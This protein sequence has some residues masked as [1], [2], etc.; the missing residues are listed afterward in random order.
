MS[1]NTTKLNCV[2]AHYELLFVNQANR[3]HVGR[4]VLQLLLDNKVLM[5]ELAAG[6]RCA[7]FQKIFS[8]TDYGAQLGLC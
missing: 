8:T 2:R 6:N 7:Q 3:L 4:G 5:Y 1:L